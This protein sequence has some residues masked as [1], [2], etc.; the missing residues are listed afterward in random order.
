MTA[1][2]ALLSAGTLLSLGACRA[3][4]RPTVLEPPMPTVHTPPGIQAALRISFA[5]LPQY[6]TPAFPA[7]YRALVRARTNAPVDN[8]VTDQGALLGRVLFHETQ[9]SRTNT[10]SC[11]S[12]H[13]QSA[14]FS[15]TAR[16]S[17][18]ID[19]VSRTGAH[20]MRLAN[21]RFFVSGRAFWDQRAPTLESQALQPIRDAVEMGF[22][23]AHGGIPALVARLGGHL[24]YRELFAYAF[25]DSTVTG[26]RIARALAQYVRSIVSVDS[27][28]DEGF[29]RAFNPLLPDSGLGAPFPTFTDAENR[30]KSL[31]QRRIN[32]GGAGCAE[33]HLP[34]TF[35]LELDG[36]GNGLDAD[37]TR[38]FKAP[39]L[40]NVA[41]DGAFM[42]DGRF[43]TLEAVVEHYNS[44]MQPAPS[45]DSRLR[46]ADRSPIRLGL[47]AADKAALVAYLRTL[48]DEMITTDP[49]FSDPF[50]R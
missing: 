46:N 12:C 28:F 6:A 43:A 30:G 7:H 26:D 29:S 36:E 38:H 19:G 49:R 15:D 5:A 32:Q 18:G 16:F 8:P 42:H 3:E 31:F 47:S 39:S 11:A 9:L 41:L 34:P 50:R 44:G 25:G 33:C 17:L 10:R 48:T 21:S 22:D 24:Y 40:R 23:D 1:L 13:I 37:E 4:P 27:R 14:G 20:S 35:A 2:R 45:L